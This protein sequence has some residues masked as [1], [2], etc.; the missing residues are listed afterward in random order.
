MGSVCGA[1]FLMAEGIENIDFN[2]II[3]LNETA[4]FLWEAMGD[5]QFTTE[6]LVEKLTA[7]YEVTPAEA[8]DCIEEFLSDLKRAGVIEE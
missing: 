8:K 5:D 6:E 1:K 7:E 3:S 4:A 2:Q